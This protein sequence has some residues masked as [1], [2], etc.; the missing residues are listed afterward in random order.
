METLI[1]PEK[2][3]EI[4]GIT[5]KSLANSR[6]TRTGIDIPYI[7]LGNRIRYQESDLIAYIAK[8][9]TNNTETKEVS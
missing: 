5:V 2:A 9:K 6:Y 7:K 3:S 4:L 1:S 8:N